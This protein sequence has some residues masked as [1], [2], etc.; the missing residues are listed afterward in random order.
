M[1]RHKKKF[2][3][4]CI[5]LNTQQ[6]I[7]RNLKHTL[8]YIHEACNAGAEFILTPEITNTISLKKKDLLK[9]TFYEK[10]D[11][12]LNEISFLAKD[13]SVWILIGSLII[14]D[15]GNRLFNRSFLINPGGK[16]VCKYDKIHMFDAMISKKEFYKESSV[17]SKGSKIIT[18]QLPW[19]K[20]GMSICYD[21]RFP[22]L[23]RK[24]SSNGADLISIPSAFTRPTG[25]AHWHTLIRA[26]AI[27]NSCFIFAPAQCGKNSSYRKTYGHSLIISP[28]G[29]IIAEKEDKP[30]I[31]LANIDMSYVEKVRKMIPSYKLKTLLKNNN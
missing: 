17:F 25:K 29:E 5:Q 11:P 22:D 23:Y 10:D 27:E 21:L 9:I 28:W 8:K 2:K 30:G 31:I 19:G 7:L 3:V 15:K 13:R 18:A 24:L 12:F 26:R 20:L 6:S 16:L 4:A 14:K 1:N